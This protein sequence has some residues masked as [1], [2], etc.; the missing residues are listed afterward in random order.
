MEDSKGAWGIILRA[1]HLPRSIRP[2]NGEDFLLDELQE[3]IGGGYIE[4]VSSRIK[5]CVLVL[6]EDGKMKGLPFNADATA[7][8][9]LKGMDYIAGDVLFC[10]RHCIK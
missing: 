8:Y 5:D 2:E 3:A 4:V 1:G 10:P 9:D 6:D 7:M